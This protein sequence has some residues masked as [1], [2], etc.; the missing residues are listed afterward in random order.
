MFNST[1]FHYKP[2][3]GRVFI[4]SVLRTPKWFHCLFLFALVY[5]KK[6]IVTCKIVSFLCSLDNLLQKNIIV[7]C[8]ENQISKCRSFEK[9]AIFDLFFTFYYYYLFHFILFM[10]FNL[11]FIFFYFYLFYLFIF[12]SIYYFFVTR[13]KTQKSLKH[14]LTYIY[15]RILLTLLTFFA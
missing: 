14:I 2:V 8:F 4:K 5:G 10:L 13:K 12:L 1:S 7:F 6:V 3:T 15:T 9:I 11:L